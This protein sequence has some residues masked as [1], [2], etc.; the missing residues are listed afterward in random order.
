MNEVVL[1]EAMDELVRNPE[2][3][4]ARRAMISF[5][6]PS[7]SKMVKY[8]VGGEAPLLVLTELTL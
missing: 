2:L 5:G 4:S 8:R 7:S 1:S 3:A 6:S